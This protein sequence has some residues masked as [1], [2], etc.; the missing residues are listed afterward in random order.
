MNIYIDESGTFANPQ[1]KAHSISTIASLIIPEI[2]L[3]DIEKEFLSLKKL[4][5]IQEIEIKGSK[6]NEN[7]VA[8]V[9]N[10]LLNYDTI[11]ELSVID[12]GLHNDAEIDEHKNKQAD[13]LFEHIDEERSPILAENTRLLQ[14]KLRSLSNQLYV[15]S[16]LI[17]ECIW[18]ALQTSTIYYSQ[19]MPSELSSFNWII[20]AKD[21]NLTKYEEYWLTI[22]AAYIQTKSIRD[23][24]ITLVEG[25]YSYFKKYYRKIPDYL[26]EHIQNSDQEL[27]LDLT[28]IFR[29]SLTFLNSKDN[30]GLQMADI[31]TNTI[32][33]ALINNLQESG[34]RKL[35]ELLINW[36]N[37]SIHFI[38]LVESK[39]VNM[40]ELPYHKILN[41]IHQKSRYPL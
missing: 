12:I 27:H 21:K 22:I 17:V 10:L 19:K 29:E 34:W 26:Q 37:I 25:D 32:R 14:E 30:L 6:L 8:D 2:Q 5:G 13:K 3:P 35:G 28:K 38:G 16:C 7:Q 4:W 36:K 1:K 11:L 9:I 40:R 31:L 20:D 33:R 39:R 41:S 23:P 18:R 15:E 24:L